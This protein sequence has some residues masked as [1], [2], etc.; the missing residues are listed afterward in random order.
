VLWLALMVWAGLGALADAP[1]IAAAVSDQVWTAS[2]IAIGMGTYVLMKA[3]HELGHGWVA[4]RYGAE[5]REMGV[6]FLV[7]I[8]VPYVEASEAA[9]LPSRWQRAAVS[10]AGIIVETTFAALAFL[11]WRDMEPGLARAVAFNIMLIGSLSTVLVNGNPLLKFDG[12]FVF[13][14]VFGLPNLAQRAT[15]FWADFTQKRL[16]GA[17]NIKPKPDSWPEKAV[18]AV[19][20][21]L[22][23]GYR[24]FLSVTIAAYVAGSSFV[25]GVV[26][27]IWSVGL[28]LGKLVAKALWHLFTAPVL[29]RV[30]RRAV[31]DGGGRGAG[32]GAALCR[33][34]ALCDGH[35]GRYLGRV[36]DRG[37]R[38]GTRIGR[39]GAGRARRA[40]GAGGGTFA[41]GR[42]VGRGAA[43]GAGLA[44]YRIASGARERPRHRARRRSPARV[45]TRHRPARPVA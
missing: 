4:R 28:S 6:M 1:A 42:S 36:G 39:R 10:G 20:A 35:A 19:Y 18:F 16:F 45:R 40:G 13:T 37:A 2:S 29:H 30:R 3:V 11:V 27:A 23:F 32:G 25:L 8:P 33:A 12:Y 43:G 31:A 5:V 44:R 41:A 21:P 7:F 24:I 22:A 15:K 17:E 34:A 9:A 14:D 26:L 38:H